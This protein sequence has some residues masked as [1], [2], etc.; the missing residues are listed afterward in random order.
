M[1]YNK[2]LK[3][4]SGLS[5]SEKKVQTYIEENPTK[6]EMLTINKLALNAGTSVASAQRYIKKLGFS[7]YKEFKF[8][9]LNQV[10][11]E[12]SDNNFDK[13]SKKYID[14]YKNV[15][16][17]FS[18]INNKSFRHLVECLLNDQPNYCLGVYYSSLPTHLLSLELQDLGAT[19]FYADDCI[20]GEHMLANATPE[21]TIVLFSVT[22]AKLYYEEFW[23]DAIKNCKN[24]F[25]ITMNEDSELKD[26][27]NNVI[28]L[29]GKNFTQTLPFDPQSIPSIFVELV[30]QTA[31][32]M[33]LKNKK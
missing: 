12:S 4:C 10:A 20:N 27:F 22:G 26:S 16:D 28:V 29:P 24:T 23:G 5:K 31:Y 1:P 17:S 14:S 25:L 19:T 8:V 13:I 2:P 11:Q 6:I 30:I 21:S 18:T 7:G 33:K 3:I 9:F 15:L 32:K